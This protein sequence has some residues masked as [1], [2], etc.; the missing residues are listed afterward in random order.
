LKVSANAQIAMQCFE[1]FGGGAFAPRGC[2]AVR[3]PPQK[4]ICCI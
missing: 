3:N 4:G 1:I 2:A